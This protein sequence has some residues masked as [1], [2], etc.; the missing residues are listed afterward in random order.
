MIAG[1]T[2]MMQQY[3]ELKEQHK[4]CLLFFR[5]GDFYEMFFEDAVTA[6]KE[7]EIVLTGRDCGLSER[8]PMCGVPYHA[9]D[10]YVNKLIEKGYKV[11]I[12]EQLTDPKESQGLVERGIIRIITP[13]TVIEESM[14]HEN[15][16][17]YIV[18]ISYSEENTGIAY[19]DVSTGAFYVCQF[20]NMADNSNIYD[21]IVRIRPREI[22]ANDAFMLH[23]GIAKRLQNMFY[24]Q[25]YHSWAY[26]PHN[27]FSKLCSHFKVQT[28]SCYGCENMI[29]AIN[30]AGALI[31][32]L[33]E[34]QKNAL[35]HI[36]KISAYTRSE[37]MMLD[38]ATIQNLELVMPIRS[39][40]KKRNTLINVLDQTVTSMGARLVRVWLEQPLQSIEAID[41]RLDAVEE[42]SQR[43]IERDALRG[44]LGNIYDIERLCSK[45]AYGSINARECV[46]LR[47]SL[48]KLKELVISTAK[49]TCKPLMRINSELDLMDDI[50]KLLFT[51]I[52]D[53]PPALL[54][55]GGFIKPGYNKD[56]DELR[57]IA[58]SSKDWLAALEVRERENTGIKNL[59]V[60][61]NRVFGFY[62]E[63]TK[64]YQGLVPETYQ[65]KQTL[66][67]A[68]RYVNQELKEL[69]E[70]ILGSEEKLIALENKLFTEI[71]TILLN[72]IDRLQKDAKLIAQLDVFSSL[73]KIAVDNNYCRPQFNND[74]IIDI[75]EGRHPVVE[76]N[77]KGD[78][79]PNNTLLD[80]KGNRIVILTGPNMAGKSTY[81]RQVALITLIA[82]IGSFVPAK[83]ATLPL[84]D[85][86]FTRIG[87]S[88]D[89]AAG[90][91]TFM[92]E[93]TEMSNI[94]NNA[95]ERSLLIIDEIGRGT[96]TFDGLSI[97]W[98]VLEHIADK[99]KCGAKTLFATHYHELTELESKLDGLK[100]YRITVKEVGDDIIF[101]RRVVK[102]GTDKSFGIQVARLAGLPD[103]VIQRAKAILVQLEKADINHDAIMQ[104]SNGVAQT[105][106]FGSS[107]PDDIMTEL[108]NVDVDSLS[109]RDAMN[110]LYDLHIRAK[111]R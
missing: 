102:G 4:D 92:V 81:M 24:M 34:T 87:A 36:N 98:A 70:R 83:S 105:N 27:A 43:Q 59:R 61:Y 19:C 74:G 111:L 55:D 39:S 91:S 18:S 60:G 50:A 73:A 99:S 93:M 52:I 58:D 47:T 23:D 51:A 68:E 75:K 5:L 32:Y 45:I 109:P 66:A 21:E 41:E 100:N 101:L 3:L 25:H 95:T 30:S 40:G 69:E 42:L 63:V 77:L 48:D 88:D 84:V 56:A 9:V 20:A 17:S 28:L 54:K 103:S 13:G 71:K 94:L 35:L 44:A 33:E 97:A 29:E 11:A 26:E 8:A 79:V 22:I 96:S 57:C 64:S 7:L 80:N 86:I 49:F 2:P 67:N 76:R 65:R 72:C 15:E 85:R 82:H 108:R 107:N 53:A 14:L 16:N 62:I 10:S 37:Y 106:L 78:F 89:L 31:A 90:E 38:A 104:E 46:A 110:K 6:S 12:C 1:L